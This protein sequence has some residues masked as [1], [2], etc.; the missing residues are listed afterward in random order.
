MFGWSQAELVLPPKWIFTQKFIVELSFG[1]NEL[2]QD[3]FISLLSQTQCSHS[4]SQV[5]LKT[6]LKKTERVKGTRI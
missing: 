4:Q 2:T 1:R 6:V 5:N 3:Q